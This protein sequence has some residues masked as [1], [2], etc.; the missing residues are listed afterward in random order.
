M[1]IAYI[2]ASI[3]I[4][5]G[6]LALKSKSLKIRLLVILL[7]VIFMALGIQGIT[8]VALY[9]ATTRTLSVVHMDHAKGFWDSLKRWWEQED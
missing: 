6:L 1:M 4:L 8:L 3:V 5:E 7:V 9:W 2:I